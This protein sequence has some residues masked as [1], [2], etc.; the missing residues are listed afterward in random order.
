LTRY[1][2]STDTKEL[3]RDFSSVCPS[4][5]ISGGSDPMYMSWDTDVIG[6]RCSSGFGFAYRISTDT[7]GTPLATTVGRV[8]I[9][10]ASGTLLFLAN[11]GDSAEVYDF[12]MNF[13]RNLSDVANPLDHAS[14][15]R[16]GNGK[17]THNSV[18]F[19]GTSDSLVTVTMNDGSYRVIVG[20]PKGYP[21]PPGRVTT[22][23]PLH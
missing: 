7:V 9:A 14:L 1:F 8:P 21:Y 20:P 3:V 23:L 11:T 15:G 13:V 2:V 18:A 4:G 22:F 16:L 12:K 10:S 19:D 6:F 5:S 17:D